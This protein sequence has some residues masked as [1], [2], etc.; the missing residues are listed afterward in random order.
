MTDLE[1]ELRSQFRTVRNRLDVASP[2]P[3]RVFGRRRGRR[4]LHR[5]LAVVLGAGIAVGG[6][7][8][9]AIALTSTRPATTPVATTTTTAAPPTT[10]SVPPAP[11]TVPPSALP[12]A[13]NCDPQSGGSGFEPSTIFIGCATSA[14]NLGNITWSSWTATMATGTAVHNVNT[15]QPD[16]AA[17][18]FASAPV[19]VTL[20]DPT[21]LQGVTEFATIAITPTTAGGSG[22]SAVDGACTA[23]AAGPCSSSGADWGFVPETP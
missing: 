11:T 5:P 4:W 16:C 23:G 7:A 22:E 2:D 15:C 10:T 1:E 14:D 17:G 6:S 9:L 19:E 18:V 21:V 20:S 12:A 8:G 3:A 13:P